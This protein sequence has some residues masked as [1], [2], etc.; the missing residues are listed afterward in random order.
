MNVAF[1]FHLRDFN[2]FTHSPAPILN[3][4]SEVYFEEQLLSQIVLSAAPTITEHVINIV[5]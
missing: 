2:V 5:S 3:L 1:F 4:V